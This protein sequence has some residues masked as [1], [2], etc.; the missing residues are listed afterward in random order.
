MQRR[1]GGKIPHW[2]R[3]K[4]AAKVNKLCSSFHFNFYVS[5]VLVSSPEPKAH[6]VS[7]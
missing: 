6:K 1:G 2:S 4:M 5:F 7:L 3:L